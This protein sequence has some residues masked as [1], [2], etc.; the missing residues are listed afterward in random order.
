MKEVK[1]FHI[2]YITYFYIHKTTTTITKYKRKEKNVANFFINNI[3]DDDV[4]DAMMS[5]KR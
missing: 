1:Y 4:R 2:K 5:T 3:K